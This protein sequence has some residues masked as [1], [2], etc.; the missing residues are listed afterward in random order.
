MKNISIGLSLWV[1]LCGGASTASAHKIHLQDGSVIRSDTVWEETLGYFMDEVSFYA[2]KKAGIPEQTVKRLEL[3]Q[4]QLI[5]SEERLLQLIRQQIGADALERYRG[6]IEKYLVK[7]EVVSYDKFGDTIHLERS[8]V[9]YIEYSSPPPSLAPGYID[10]EDEETQRAIKAEK[11]L[12][13]E[14]LRTIRDRKSAYVPDDTTV[15]PRS[16]PVDYKKEMRKTQ[17]QIKELERNPL[18]YFLRYYPELVQFSARPSSSDCYTLWS[19]EPRRRSPR[20]TMTGR[21]R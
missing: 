17:E 5:R 3:L 20:R 8:K 10:P 11:A 18:G 2:Y 15:L 7:E 4:D 1:L 13:Y 21:H 16:G 14:R 9:D 12:L 6:V 19:T